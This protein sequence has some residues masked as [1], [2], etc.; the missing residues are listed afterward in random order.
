MSMSQERERILETKSD[1]EILAL[2]ESAEYPADQFNH[3]AHL[4]VAY[5][6]LLRHPFE[7]AME[8]TKRGLRHYIGVTKPKNGYHETLTIFWVKIIHAAM[9][10]HGAEDSHLHFFGLHNHLLG[11][12]L[13][14]LF[15]TPPALFNQHASEHWVE[16]D[17]NPLSD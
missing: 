12:R 15:Y 2:F 13:P 16:P 4:T 7:E 1:D 8:R 5:L 6:Y 10:H 9:S 14:L 17:L 11:K 3:Q